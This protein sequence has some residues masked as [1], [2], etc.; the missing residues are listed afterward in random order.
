M[1]RGGRGALE[2]KEYAT[3]IRYPTLKNASLHSAR[4]EGIVVVSV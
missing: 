3:F 2:K 1:R 4:G